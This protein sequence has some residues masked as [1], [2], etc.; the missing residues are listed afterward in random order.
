MTIGNSKEK[1]RGKINYG[2]ANI[3]KPWDAVSHHAD[4][5][6]LRNFATKNGYA[7]AYIFAVP[8]MFD[9]NFDKNQRED[10]RQIKINCTF[11]LNSNLYFQYFLK[12]NTNDYIY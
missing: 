12:E 5:L 3:L 11:K 9:L 1:N 7:A 10:I 8:K 4:L 6:L 2:L